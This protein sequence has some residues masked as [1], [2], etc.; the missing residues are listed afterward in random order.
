[1]VNKGLM[2]FKPLANNN[3]YKN[4]VAVDNHE[5]DWQHRGPGGIRTISFLFVCFWASSWWT[6]TACDCFPAAAGPFNQRCRHR[7]LRFLQLLCFASFVL[8][9]R[10]TFTSINQSL[11]TTV[12]LK[13]CSGCV[14]VFIAVL[15]VCI[16][17]GLGL[18]IWCWL[19]PLCSTAGSR[20]L[21][22]SSCWS[23][24]SSDVVIYGPLL[25]VLQQLLNYCF[26]S[27]SCSLFWS[28]AFDWWLFLLQ[29]QDS[30]L[31]LR[32]HHRKLYKQYT[33][34]Y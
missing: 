30:C 18:N 26:I 2:S 1:M 31:R 7:F 34:V 29:L 3:V 11:E 32:N 10:S 8:G 28:S 20:W 17:D 24:C 25:F 16:L 15:F 9:Q 27:C 21:T 33:T 5:G 14:W 13:L 23:Y 22:S 19:Q 6:R 4:N 12:V